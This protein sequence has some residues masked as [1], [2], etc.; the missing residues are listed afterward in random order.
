MAVIWLSCACKCTE[1][2]WISRQ[3]GARGCAGPSLKLIKRNYPQSNVTWPNKRDVAT[4]TVFGN[5]PQIYMVKHPSSLLSYQLFIT[6]LPEKQHLSLAKTFNWWNVCDKNKSQQPSALRN[7]TSVNFP[8]ENSLCPW[9]WVRQLPI[10]WWQLCNVVV[11]GTTAILNLVWLHHSPSGLLAN[12]CYY[13]GDNSRPCPSSWPLTSC[14]FGPPT[15]GSL[16]LLL[17]S[18]RR[19]GVSTTVEPIIL[20]CLALPTR[21]LCAGPVLHGGCLPSNVAPL[22]P[23]PSLEGMPMHPA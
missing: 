9:A 8:L 2:E 21:A 11:W 17:A 16:S 12:H 20:G 6:F 13:Q 23:S 18:E 5:I 10:H 1:C 4:V 14:Q 15:S 22:H 7:K 19:S 3:C